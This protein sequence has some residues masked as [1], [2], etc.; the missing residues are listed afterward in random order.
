[1]IEKLQA[2]AD[3]TDPNIPGM[4]LLVAVRKDASQRS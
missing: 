3:W 2:H 1:M 4:F